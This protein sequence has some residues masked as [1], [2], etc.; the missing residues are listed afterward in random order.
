MI[1]LDTRIFEDDNTNR[2]INRSATY[3]LLLVSL[4]NKISPYAVLGNDSDS[5]DREKAFEVLSEITNLS[6]DVIFDM[7][8][9]CEYF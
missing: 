6:Y 3:R 2:D 8:L 1:T 9:N 7:W 4:K 5:I